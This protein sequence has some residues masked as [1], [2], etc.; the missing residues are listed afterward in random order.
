MMHVKDVILGFAIEI[1]RIVTPWG[2][3]S[4]Q[5]INEVLEMN[6]VNVACRQP[7]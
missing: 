4:I 7:L 2:G 1:Q 3:R 6:H 5:L